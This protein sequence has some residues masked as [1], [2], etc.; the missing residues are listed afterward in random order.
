MTENRPQ[1]VTE[2]KGHRMTDKITDESLIANLPKADG[3]LSF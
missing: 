2:K 3:Q 1:N